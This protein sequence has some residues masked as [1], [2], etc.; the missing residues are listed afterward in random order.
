VAELE[1]CGDVCEATQLLG[2]LIVVYG[3]AMAPIGWWLAPFVW[4]YTLVSFFIANA[5]KIAASRLIGHLVPSHMR[6]LAR[7]EG[8]VVA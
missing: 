8:H 5:V 2:T 3:I 6:H 1:A 7:I 4:A